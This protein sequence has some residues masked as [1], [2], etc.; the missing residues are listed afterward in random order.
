MSLLHD[1]NAERINRRLEALRH[2]LRVATTRSWPEAARAM[3]ELDKAWD[4]AE[5]VAEA[6]VPVSAPRFGDEWRRDPSAA[7]ALI[8]LLLAVRSRPGMAEVLASVLGCDVQLAGAN[9]DKLL[10][11]TVAGRGIAGRGPEIVIAA[12]R[13]VGRLP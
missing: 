4:E 1:P 9:L 5:R 6:A 2:A 8:A 3:T 11:A 12:L 13:L 7:D 10:D